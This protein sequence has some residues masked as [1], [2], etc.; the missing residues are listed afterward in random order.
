MAQ[1]PVMLLVLVVMVL[2]CLY[3]VYVRGDRLAR[4]A[5]NRALPPQLGGWAVVSA[6]PRL[7]QGRP[8]CQAA[9]L[10]T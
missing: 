1:S 5:A 2:M 8:R 9:P 6:S 10:S 3:V 7:L 4:S